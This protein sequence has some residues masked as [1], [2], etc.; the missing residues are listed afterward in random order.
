MMHALD[1]QNDE[2]VSIMW[3]STIMQQSSVLTGAI[4]TFTTDI[5]VANIM[6]AI[7]FLTYFHIIFVCYRCWCRFKLISSKFTLNNGNS[8]QSS[9]TFHFLTLASH[10]PIIFS[11]DGKIQDQ[12]KVSMTVDNVIDNIQAV[13]VLLGTKLTFYCTL[14]WTLFVLIYSLGMLQLISI[15]VEWIALSVT[16][17]IA[18]FIYAQILCSSHGMTLSNENILTFMLFLEEKSN[19]SVRLFLFTF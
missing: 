7:S 10:K 2:D 17:I 11:S 9:D 8:H 13:G 5:R 3:I 18:K 1:I 4:A 14:T 12:S 16:D 19:I 15:K 6:M